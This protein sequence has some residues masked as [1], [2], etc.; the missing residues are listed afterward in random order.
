MQILLHGLNGNLVKAIN[1]LLTI[2]CEMSCLLI[3]EK[4]ARRENR[5]AVCVCYDLA[6][7]FQIWRG[8]FMYAIK[9]FA[10][11]K[12]HQVVLGL[13]ACFDENEEVEVIVLSKKRA[14]LDYDF[15][16]SDELEQV[17]KIG[18]N[19]KSFVEDDEDYSTW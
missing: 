7:T 8:V 15:W 9:E 14:E 6:D 13:P 1:H 17:G 12:N 19:S 16:N 3:L 10:T 5:G 11:V 2:R 4:T 18:L